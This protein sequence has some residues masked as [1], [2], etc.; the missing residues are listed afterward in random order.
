[1]IATSPAVTSVPT[2]STSCV[3]V[4]IVARDLSALAPS[5]FSSLFFFII[6]RASMPLSPPATLV[7]F[8]PLSD[9]VEP[10]DDDCASCCISSADFT[11]SSV[12]VVWIADPCSLAPS[13]VIFPIACFIIGYIAVAAAICSGETPGVMPP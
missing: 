8:D 2:F 13:V 3:D 11:A 10:D 12:V 6:L 4:M 9:C 5:L 1:G 7:G